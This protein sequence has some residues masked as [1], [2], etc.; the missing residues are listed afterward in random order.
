[1]RQVRLWIAS[2]LDGYIARK[3]GS[4]DWLYAMENPEK[5]DYGYQEFY[6]QIGSVIMG[7]KTYDEILSY[8]V[9]WPYSDSKS[10]IFSFNEN[11]KVKTANT[12][13]FTGQL[14]KLI[15]TLKEEEE[16]DI[17]LVGGGQL[18]TA[19]LNDDLIDEMTI[20]LIPILL[21][22]GIPLFPGKPKETQFE[23]IDTKC[24]DNGVVNLNY[25]K[26]TS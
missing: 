8:G 18:I 11:Y 4:L 2:T 24:Y 3:S 13:I 26:K 9:D 20:S 10:Y 5:S 22:E 23:L 14:T 19:F 15:K 6:S 1:M 7:R 21:G 17:W 25:R 12:S 16:N